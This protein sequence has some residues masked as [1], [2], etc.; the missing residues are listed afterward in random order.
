M[1]LKLPTFWSSQPEVWFAQAEAQ[2]NLRKITADDTKYYYVL[3]AL[4]QPTATRL[5]DLI[6]HPPA[7]DKYEAL[8]T[9]LIDTFGPSERERASRLLH[10][11]ELGDTKP[12]VLMD[13][14]LALLGDH[15]PCF[16][17]Q[18]LFLERLHE[19]IRVQLVDSEADDY[20][21]LAKKADA[22]WASRDMSFS[23]NA[24]QRRLSSQKLKAKHPTTPTADDLCYYHRSF[25]QAARKCTKPCSWSGKE[26]AI[27][28]MAASHNTGLFFL[29]DKISGRQFLV[30][31]G[32]EIS[33]IPATASDKCNTHDKQGP[34]LSAANGTTIKTYGSRI[35]P[36]QFASKGYQWSFTIADVSRPLLG[37][38]FLRSN[39]LLVDLTGRRLVDA[40]TYHSVPL[41]ATRTPALHLN[42]VTS[43]QY[44]T[45]LSKFPEITM[46]VFTQAAIKHTV[47]HFISTKGPP[48]HARPRR[49]CPDKLVAA[50]AEFANM[51]AMGLIR[52][53]SSPWASPLHMVPKASGGWRP[54]GDYRRLNDITIPDKYPVPHIHDFS[55]QLAGKKIFSKIDLVRGYHQIPVTAEDIPKTAIITPFGL[56]EFLRMPFG[57]KNAAQVFQRL[58]DT[59]CQ[60]LDFTFVYIDD[61]L[62]AS[63]DED[64]HLA[65]LHQLFQRLKDYGLVVNVSKCKF[66]VKSLD[67]LGHHINCD[68]IVPLPDKVS[69]ITEYP[70][71]ETVK[72]LQEFVGMV[73]FYHR[74]I[75]AAAQLMSPLFEALTS[76]TKTLV[77]NDTMTQAFDNIKKALAK[78][79]LLA[80][81]RH[82]APISLTTDASDRAVGAVLQ[83][84][85][86]ESWEPLAFFSKKLR[87][88]EQKYS[89]FDRELLALYL[90]IRHFRH[91]LEGRKFTAYTDH[92]PLIFC[93]SKVSEPW[94][95]RQQRQLSYISEFTT[96]IQH[97]QGKDNPVADSLSRA[98][99]DSVQL[100]IDYSVMAADQKDDPEIQAY[101]T[102]PTSLLFKEVPFGQQGITL[103]CDTS[104]GQ[105]R[106]VVPVSWRRKVFDL[107][108]G[109]SH[110]SIRATRKLISSK[111][112]WKG[113]NSQVGSW[114]KTC[115]QCQSSKIH[116]HIKSPLETFNVP[117]RRFDHIH[118]DLVGPL[119][120]SDGFT[121][122]LTIVDR[123]SRWPEAVPLNDIS[124]VAC[125]RALIYHWISR[126]GIP[127]DMSS[128]RGSQFTSQLWSS[129]A[130]LLGIT[131]HH[132]T[133]Y[134]PQA[135]G[136][137]E[138]FHRHLKT[139]LRARLTGP[140]WAQ[141]LPWVLL[142]IRTAPKE[143]LGCS[144]AELVYGAPVT[145]P[146]E[147]FPAHTSQPNHNSELQRLREQVQALV[148]IS[149]SHHGI[150]PISIPPDLQHS[151]YVFI[152]RD[153]HRTPLQRPY[154]GPFK[155]LRPG[156]KN[157]TID[158]GGRKDTV[159][160]DRLKPAHI[161][162]EFQVPV[163][164]AKH[165][166]RPPRKV[167]PTSTQSHTPDSLSDIPLPLHTRSGR[168]VNLPRRFIS[169]LGGVV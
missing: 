144:S 118:V 27:V 16:L 139:S 4:D 36:L 76:Q 35:V 126:F 64:T 24:V 78:A 44:N 57:L 67:F 151:Q 49:L 23:T 155:V 82:D 135:N 55:A 18:Q 169:V 39:S 10:F 163:A 116:T 56:Y 66:G 41:G 40:E 26:Q 107:I 79:T 46:P 113:M 2:F 60:G 89:A 122:L 88:P 115:I 168:Q 125:A 25:G 112:I 94:S 149:T 31:T 147:F 164:V 3:A 90:G 84:W 63:E 73:N 28:A 1:S 158:I 141:E 50:K 13:E 99:L 65:H 156:E 75:P 12:S 53:S 42:A 102:T 110:P 157:F 5:L 132:T 71:P 97:I 109:L 68:G 87:P 8:K 14:M 100:G 131:L 95:N 93:M 81:P 105:A 32:A 160:V 74:F 121:H 77:W 29:W 83:Q 104:T 98:T 129:V 166:G 21:H 37:A 6:S 70:Q 34:L 106:P 152:R 62:V 124:T 48:V 96:D 11:C 143:D 51:E 101:L 140:Q 111:F 19:D 91:F 58:M 43:N 92:K 150:T 142:G 33:V 162:P 85:T 138:R 128:D 20:R 167:Q 30:D 38:D 54:C 123:F 136:L 52:R 120:P 154:E 61:I 47:E 145:V 119:P 7:D 153:S 9:R 127:M 148:P 134:H 146:G 108:H 130:K 165:R 80:H 22:L 69:V 161:D 159:S 86:D 59:V 133:A 15:S 114:A 17:F 117:H 137:V 45:L 72:A 103:L